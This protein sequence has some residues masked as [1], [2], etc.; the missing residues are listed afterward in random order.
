MVSNNA[1]KV[2]LTLTT[3]FQLY[4][5]RKLKFQV[6]LPAKSESQLQ[7]S[8]APYKYHCVHC[9]AW[10]IRFWETQIYWKEI[11]WSWIINNIEL[12]IDRHIC[13]CSVSSFMRNTLVLYM[14]TRFWLLGVESRDFF[15]CWERKNCMQSLTNSQ[16]INYFHMTQLPTAKN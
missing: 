9:C 4:L 2:L 16:N 1:K 11:L 14:S 12:K 13:Q 6:S 5:Y 3:S 10:F 7:Y 8:F 15:S